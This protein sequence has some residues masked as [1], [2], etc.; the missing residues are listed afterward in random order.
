MFVTNMEDQLI[1]WVELLDDR[2]RV[3]LDCPVED[4]FIRWVELG[5]TPRSAGSYYSTREPADF[6]GHEFAFTLSD[7]LVY[8]GDTLD[9]GPDMDEIRG[10]P[11]FSCIIF[12]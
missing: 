5:A 4:K 2:D 7:G 10:C 8:A 1:R 6:C 9:R 3:R 12:I 11:R